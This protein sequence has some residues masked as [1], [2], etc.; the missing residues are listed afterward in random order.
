MHVC[1]CVPSAQV[2]PNADTGFILS[3][4]V[5]MLNTDLHNPN[6]KPE[7]KMTKEGFISTNRGIAAGQDLPRE[8]LINIYDAI[9]ARPISLKEDD[10][11]REKAQV[12]A[13]SVHPRVLA[14]RVHCR[15]MIRACVFRRRSALC[16]RCFLYAYFL[17]SQLCLFVC[18]FDLLLLLHFYLD[19]PA[20]GLFAISASVPFLVCFRL[21][22]RSPMKS[23]SGSCSSRSDRRWSPLARIC[24][25][26]TLA[27]TLR[28]GVHCRTSPSTI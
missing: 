24:F 4:S 1:T 6:V 20:V 10:K 21:R 2:F 3:Y 15:L 9:K 26:P 14:C 11:L 28:T 17:A 22:K 13:P 18:L 7:K 25:A 16:A 12:R 27:T 5:I 19:C 8:V 23:K